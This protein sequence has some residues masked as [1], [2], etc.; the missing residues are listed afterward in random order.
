MVA[1]GERVILSYLVF[2]LKVLRVLCSTDV[3]LLR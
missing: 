1:V 2:L 3:D